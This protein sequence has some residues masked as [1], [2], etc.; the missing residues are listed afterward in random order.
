[1]FSGVFQRRRLGHG[2]AGGCKRVKLTR[3]A[4]IPSW[5]YCS[6]N[7]LRASAISKM[8]RQTLLLQAFPP[9]TLFCS[10]QR[11][12]SKR[13]AIEPSS[14]AVANA[15]LRICCKMQLARRWETCHYGARREDALVLM[16]QEGNLVD[17]E[18][19]VKLL[20]RSFSMDPPTLS[21]YEALL[22][23]ILLL[24]FS[25]FSHRSSILLS[26][27]QHSCQQFLRAFWIS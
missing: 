20:D 16:R 18:S 12:F 19:S 7:G 5:G 11:S 22:P 26:C 9:T 14:L 15:L 17:M 21:I 25:S 6:P 24:S 2:N 3:K 23:C 8:S 4:L 1:M 13:S 10:A 27:S